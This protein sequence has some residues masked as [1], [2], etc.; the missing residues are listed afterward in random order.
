MIK[1]EAAAAGIGVASLF[2]S[3]FAILAEPAHE[4]PSRSHATRIS[5]GLGVHTDGSGRSDAVRYFHLRGRSSKR[6]W[7]KERCRGRAGLHI[8]SAGWKIFRAVGLPCKRMPAHVKVTDA[9][10]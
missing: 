1:G 3:L 2:A 8:A 10:K 6:C 9:G 4:T 7:R 5:N